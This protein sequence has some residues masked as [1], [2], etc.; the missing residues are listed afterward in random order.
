MALVL[1]AALTTAFSVSWLWSNAAAVSPVDVPAGTAGDVKTISPSLPPSPTPTPEGKV[2]GGLFYTGTLDTMPMMSSAWKSSSD[3]AGLAAGAGSY[4]AVHENYDGKADWVSYVG[5]GSLSK[6]IPFTNTP[7]GLKDAT[8]KATTN[9]LVALYDPNV[10]LIGKATHR[11]I[12]VAGHQGHELTIKVDVRKPKL[13]ETFSTVMVA[14]I[15]RG[16]GTAVVSVADIAG[17]T[18]QWLPVWRTAVS[19]IEFGD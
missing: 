1:V 5:F 18:P 6:S 19:Q 15:D 13:P 12:T 4:L 3:R 8:I 10:K 9:A 7:A 11:P 16:D 17:S 2:I 14:V